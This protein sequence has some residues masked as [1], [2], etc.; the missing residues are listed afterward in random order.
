MFYTQSKEKDAGVGNQSDYA[1]IY[2]RDLGEVGIGLEYAQISSS[3]MK[4][5]NSTFLGY[6]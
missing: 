2:E 6:D 5:G 4:D 1:G 3:E